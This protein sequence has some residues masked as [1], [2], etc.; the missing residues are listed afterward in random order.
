[1]S[2]N[3]PTPES[4]TQVGSSA[5]AKP[6]SNDSPTPLR[7]FLGAIISGSIGTARYWLTQ[8]IVAG[9]ANKPLPTG[10]YIATN[11]AVAVRTLVMGMSALATGIFVIAALGL[12]ALGIQLLIQQLRQPST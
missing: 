10:N 7:C 3:R 8:S 9:F 5:A 1:M 2:E 4:S 11:I 6:S 12:V